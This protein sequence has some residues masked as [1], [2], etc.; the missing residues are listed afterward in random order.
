MAPRTDELS[1]PD[2]E[3]DSDADDRPTVT[4]HRTHADRTVL[5]ESDNKEAWIATDLTIEDWR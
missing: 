4:A 1:V 3:P 5:T 2:D